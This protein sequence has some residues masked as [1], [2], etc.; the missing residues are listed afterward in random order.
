MGILKKA[1]DLVYT[2]RFLKLLTTSFKDTKAYELG[3]VDEDGKKLKKA[4]TA[5]EKDAYTPFIRLVFNIKR[6]MGKAPGGSSK[7]ASYAAA[8]YLIKENYGISEKKI[9]EAL[10]IKIEDLLWESN[11][12]FVLEDGRLSPGLYRLKNEKVLSEGLHDVVREKDQ[13][14]VN[15]DC[16]PVGTMMGIPIYEALH[17]PTKRKI[18][19]TSA[20]II[21]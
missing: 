12:W 18:H 15:N 7:L 16:Y 20:E 4:T 10:G 14:R 8:L 17:I 9:E 5:E 19:I 11:Q 3:L 21:K 2:F 13:I 1:G 6:L